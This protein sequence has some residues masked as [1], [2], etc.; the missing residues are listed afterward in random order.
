MPSKS[1]YKLDENI[2]KIINTNEKA[3]WLGFIFG[4]GSV[5]KTRLRI[6]LSIQDEKH[7]IK[8]RDFL[9]SDHILTYDNRGCVTISISSS[10]LIKDLHQY[11]IIKNKTYLTNKL[12]L[13]SNDLFLYFVL[14]L[15]DS[16]GWITEHKLKKQ[17]SQFEFGFSN[18]HNEILLEI[19]N[20][21]SNQLNKNVGYI[22]TRE[23]KCPQ[24][25]I[26]GNNNFINLYNLFY[27]KYNYFTLDRKREKANI[28]Y[29]QLYN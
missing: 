1:K 5:D 20:W 23:N 9:K 18:Y 6:S 22:S 26:G 8:F 25:I 7:L 11:G 15:L 17:K 12:P 19:K 3:Y 2:F 4:D 21:I 13:L 16:D 10:T 24:L 28:A 14:G 27:K 29:M